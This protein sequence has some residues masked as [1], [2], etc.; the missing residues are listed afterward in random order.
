MFQHADAAG[1]PKGQFLLPGI[2]EVIILQFTVFGNIH[3]G[4]E[5]CAF[6]WK[7]KQE[8]QETVTL[9]QTSIILLVIL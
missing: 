2:S 9:V 5:L 1:F 4:L 6:C 3:S 8:L 7:A